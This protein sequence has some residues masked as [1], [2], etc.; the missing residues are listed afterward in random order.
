MGKAKSDEVI[1]EKRLGFHSGTFEQ[2]AKDVKLL[3]EDE[4]LRTGMGMNGKRYVKEEHDIKKVVRHYIALF[5]RPHGAILL[6]E[7]R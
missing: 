2:M 3:L 1:C 4:R 6:R 7:R 5:K